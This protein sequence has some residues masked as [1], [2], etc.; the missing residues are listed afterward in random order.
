M[1]IKVL[2][3]M[4]AELDFYK[5]D[6]QMPD[7]PL[8]SA[9][10]INLARNTLKKNIDKFK[11]EQYALRQ[12][13]DWEEIYEYMNLLIVNNGKEK[14]LGEDYTI[15][16]PRSEAAAYL[17]WILWRAFLAIDH[18]VNKPYEVYNWAKAY[19]GFNQREDEGEIVRL[20][21][22]KV[23]KYLQKEDRLTTDKN[24]DDTSCNVVVD[25]EENNV[26]DE[27][28]EEELESSFDSE[29]QKQGLKLLLDIV[30]MVHQIKQGISRWEKTFDYKDYCSNIKYQLKGEVVFKKE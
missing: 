16:V 24:E 10:N 15:K 26:Y 7:I 17:E 4:I 29:K 9:K 21:W 25:D 27:D 23:E 22:D 2:N 1:A 11:E 3:D 30:L 6:Y 8:D 13:N 12:V 20:Y 5:I 28:D 19:I 14:E 18:T